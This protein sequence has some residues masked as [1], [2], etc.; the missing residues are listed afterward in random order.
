M[1]KILF[2]FFLLLVILASGYSLFGIGH[3]K[4]MY[5][6]VENPSAE[7]LTLQNKSAPIKMVEF[8]NY[9]CG[10]CKELHPTIQELLSVRKDIE[11][12]V[13]PIAFGE[14]ITNDLTHIALAAGLQDRFW[15]F[16][17]AFL[18]YPED[19]IP[20]DF[21]IETA[22]LYGVDYAQLIKDSKSRKVKELAQE[23]DNALGHAGLGSVPSF[24]INRN[25]YYVDERG[26]PDLKTMLDIVA[27]AQK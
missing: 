14:G 10:F 23:N 22:N 9:G 19:D 6:K 1:K 25:F 18:E 7:F 11:Y 21:I 4:W 27:A 12:V 2:R 20:D 5:N 8:I 16:N 24:M 3:F 13:R 17:N 26:V 15:E